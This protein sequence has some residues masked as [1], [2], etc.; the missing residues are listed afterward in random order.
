MM[1]INGLGIRFSSGFSFLCRCRGIHRIAKLLRRLE[2]RDSFRRNIYLVAGLGITPGT[3]I[4]LAGAKASEAT[5]LDFVTGFEGANDGLEKSVDDDLSI[6]AGEV[7]QGG[8]FVYEVCFGHKRI[9]FVPWEAVEV[10]CK[11]PCY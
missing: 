1:G 7:A 3:R 4:A 10:R 11:V 2:E 9:P 6:A 8:H 5:Y